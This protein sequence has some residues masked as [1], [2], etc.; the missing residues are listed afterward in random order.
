M[1][2][3]SNIVCIVSQRADDAEIGCLLDITL[4]KMMII[5]MVKALFSALK[6]GTWYKTMCE[7]KLLNKQAMNKGNTSS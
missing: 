1:Q 5:V 3:V 6:V 4:K 2:R 7:Y